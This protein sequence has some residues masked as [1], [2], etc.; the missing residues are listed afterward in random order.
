MLWCMKF[1]QI[2]IILKNTVYY[3]QKKH[4]TSIKSQT[5]NVL[6]PLKA[7]CFLYVL[8][9]ITY[10]ISTVCSERLFMYFV[11]IS[12]ERVILVM[13][14]GSLSLLKHSGFAQAYNFYIV[15]NLTSTRGW[16]IL[17]ECWRLISHLYQNRIC[18][19]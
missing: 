2:W 10:K 13:K 14:S 4:R 15:I 8:T 6:Q 5:L 16:V 9:G 18:W 17:I 3:L 19:S 11:L 7:T 12:A 1:I